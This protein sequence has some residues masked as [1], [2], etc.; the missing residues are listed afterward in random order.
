[1]QSILMPRKIF[2]AI[3]G[4]LATHVL[5]SAKGRV[6]AAA[7]VNSTKSVVPFNLPALSRTTRTIANMK[8]TMANPSENESLNMERSCALAGS[9]LIGDVRF[10]VRL[11]PNRTGYHVSDLNDHELF[12]PVA[13]IV[14]TPTRG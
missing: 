6:K 13:M 3:E 11:R 14:P 9:D 8:P 1:M 2:C 10:L 4:E 5:P 12:G 7:T